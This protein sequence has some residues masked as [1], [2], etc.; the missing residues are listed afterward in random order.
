MAANVLYALHPLIHFV[1]SLTYAATYNVFIC[2]NQ[3]KPT[4]ATDASPIISSLHHCARR[5]AALH[6]YRSVIH[7]DTVLL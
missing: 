7:L 3:A 4:C 1:T 6:I 5:A 2:N